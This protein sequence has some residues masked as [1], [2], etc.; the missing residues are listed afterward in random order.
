MKI[1]IAKPDFHAAGG[2]EIV[3]E[4]L[5]AGLRDRGHQVDLVQ[6]EADASPVSDLGFGGASRH[7]SY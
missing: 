3:V 6:V 7:P 5:A 2:F 1:A 4:R